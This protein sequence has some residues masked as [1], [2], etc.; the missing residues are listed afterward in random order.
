VVAEILLRAGVGNL[1]I[2][3]HDVVHESNLPRQLLYSAQDVGLPKVHAAK[4]RLEAIW[5]QAHIE[6]HEAYLEKRNL[7]LLDAADIILDGTDNFETR[8]LL[9]AYAK[10]RKI[11]YIYAGAIE[12]RGLVFP[13]LP[14]KGAPRLSDIL[15]R[16]SLST[17]CLE[18]GI[19][20]SAATLT[21]AVEASLAIRYLVTGELEPALHRIDAWTGVVEKINVPLRRTKNRPQS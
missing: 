14:K 12:T 6:A 4:A 17:S 16:A 15:P 11:P 18:A 20:S 9:D 13:V 5:P 19:L 3:D 2:L 7:K 10:R 8:M 1:I 21:A